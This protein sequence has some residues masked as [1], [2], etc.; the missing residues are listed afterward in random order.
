[1]QTVRHW[2][3]QPLLKEHVIGSIHYLQSLAVSRRH[4]CAPAIVNLA[5]KGLRL[6]HDTDMVQVVI[7]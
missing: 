1:V 7:L 6:P 2:D 3:R 4:C 5:C